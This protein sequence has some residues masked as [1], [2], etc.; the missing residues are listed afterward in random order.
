MWMKWFIFL[1]YVECNI[2]R[3]KINIPSVITANNTK[4]K[5]TAIAPKALRAEAYCL[6]S[7]QFYQILYLIFFI[8]FFVL[9]K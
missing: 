1:T 5:V 8:S 3:Q 6:C 2:L 9:F 7:Y 4:Y